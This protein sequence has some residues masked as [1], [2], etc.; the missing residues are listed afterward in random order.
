MV[1]GKKMVRICCLSAAGVVLLI[2]LTAASGWAA[3]S[4]PDWRKTYDTIMM[5][6]NF[7]ILAFVLVK[8]GKTPLVNF[9]RGQ[10]AQVSRDIKALEAEKERVTSRIDKTFKELDQSDA[11]FQ[12]IQDRIV[13]EGEKKKEELIQ[14]AREQSR[15]IIEMAKQKVENRILEAKNAFRRQLVDLAA[16][17]ALERLPKEITGEDDERMI[18]QYLA[19][20]KSV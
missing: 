12:S 16:E 17:K 15:I 4:T 7:A 9:L 8:Y 19:A 5:W 3:E 11:H 6:V 2:H 18:Q 14:E 13:R 10:S 20:S 1:Q